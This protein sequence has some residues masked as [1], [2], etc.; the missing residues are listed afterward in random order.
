MRDYPKEHLAIIRDEKVTLFVKFEIILPLLCF[1]IGPPYK[2]AQSSMVS[3]EFYDKLVDIF[4]EVSK[5]K[6]P[7]TKAK[8]L[9]IIT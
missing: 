3:M 4:Q 1:F 7:D 5:G 2:Q 8:G 9:I 6:N